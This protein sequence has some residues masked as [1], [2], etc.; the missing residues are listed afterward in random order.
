MSLHFASGIKWDSMCPQ[1]AV[2]LA[3]ASECFGEEGEDCYV[4]GLDRH[5]SGAI[6]GSKED[7]AVNGFH[8]NGRAVDLSVKR[9][10][11]G[12]AIPD[13]VMD[14][15]FDRLNTR[16]GRVGGS[17]FDVLDERYPRSDSPGWTGPHIHIEFQ[18]L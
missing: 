7:F 16:L 13:D 1:I 8:S 18:P 17:P 4:T 14:R 10:R 11:G 12:E 2:A 6:P 5:A 15:I 9:L 3:V